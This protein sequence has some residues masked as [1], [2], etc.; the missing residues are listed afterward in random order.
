MEEKKKRRSGVMNILNDVLKQFMQLILN[1]INLIVEESVDV[2]LVKFE[3]KLK[4]FQAMLNYGR[5][6]SSIFLCGAKKCSL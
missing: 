1:D 5:K 4:K 2:V 3:R 6:K